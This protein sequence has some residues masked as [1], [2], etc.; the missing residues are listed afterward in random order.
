MSIFTISVPVYEKIHFNSI[1]NVTGFVDETAKKGEIVK[2]LTRSSITS[3]NPLF[4]TYIEQITGL[5]LNKIF[6]N[7]VYQF[8]S[9]IHKDLSADLYLNG[10]MGLGLDQ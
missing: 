2:V 7:S 4:Y 3:D 10:I 9:L 5:F 1:E 8:L 6:V